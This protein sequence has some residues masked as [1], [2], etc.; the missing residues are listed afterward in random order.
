MLSM[1]KC[2]VSDLNDKLYG[3]WGYICWREHCEC[4]KP[5]S[6]LSWAYVYE[7]I[8]TTAGITMR[9]K[10]NEEHSEIRKEVKTLDRDSSNE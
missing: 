8:F 10:F 2:D 4:D 1:T 6:Y 7:V 5:Y 9:I 3:D